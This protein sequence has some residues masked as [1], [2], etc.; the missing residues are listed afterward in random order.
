MRYAIEKLHFPV[1]NITIFAWS[2]GGYSACWTAVHY[3]DIQGLILDAIF[4]DVLPLAQR[5]MPTYTSKFVEKTVRYYLDLNNIQLIKLY[6]GP[7]YLIRRAQDEIMNL[8]PG[9]LESNRANEILFVIL[10]Y[11]YPFI[12]NNDQILSLLKEYIYSNT[13]Q[14]NILRDKY[15]SDKDNFQLQ[16]EKYRLENPISSYP[17]RFGLYFTLHRIRFFNILF[18]LT[19]ENLSFDQRQCFSIYLIDEYLINF[20][21]QHCT[22]LPQNYFFLPNRCV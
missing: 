13:I 9:K 21:S 19:G 20:D 2:I 10:P 18:I 11:R 17:C 8:I 15:C 14:Q 6:N 4:D 16:T 1:N 7:F 12:Y 5:Q 22:S 3:Q